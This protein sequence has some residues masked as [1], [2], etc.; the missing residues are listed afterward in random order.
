MLPATRRGRFVLIAIVAALLC[1][2]LNGL[3]PLDYYLRDRHVAAFHHPVSG[4]ITSILIDERSVKALGLTPWPRGRIAALLKRLHELGAAKIVVWI[5][6]DRRMDSRGDSELA[7]QLRSMSGRVAIVI[8]SEGHP[9][10]GKIVLPRPEFQAYARLVHPWVLWTLWTPRAMGY[11]YDIGGHTYPSGASYLANVYSFGRTHRILELAGYRADR[12]S[13]DYTINARTIPVIS[14]IDLLNG[15]APK[16]LIQDKAILIASAYPPTVFKPQAPG[17]GEISAALAP[18]MAAE[19]LIQGVPLDLPW[20]ATFLPALLIVVICCRARKALVSI[21]LIG[22]AIT[23]LLVLPT[24][25][26]PSVYIYSGSAFFLLFLVGAGFSWS[27]V[28]KRLPSYRG[29]KLKEQ[30][31]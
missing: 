15:K 19:T 10:R 27:S 8:G 12:F 5:V 1:E 9:R 22:G 25:L 28:R 3:L 11:Q 18:V 26:F 23:T 30:N 2:S 7:A 24:F 14:A 6:L 31:I 20:T 17:I 21:I 29:P 16:R 13:I 4:E